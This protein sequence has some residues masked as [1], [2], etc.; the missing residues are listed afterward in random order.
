MTTEFYRCSDIMNFVL[1]FFI[2]LPGIITICVFVG[3]AFPPSWHGLLE[4][5]CTGLSCTGSST[6]CTSVF[7][8]KVCITRSWGG[9]ESRPCENVPCEDLTKCVYK[10]V[11]EWVDGVFFRPSFNDGILIMNH[12]G[13]LI[14]HI[15][16]LVATYVTLVC[17]VAY[18]IIKL[19]L[20]IDTTLFD[21]VMGVAQLVTLFIFTYIIRSPLLSVMTDIYT[22]FMR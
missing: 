3:S 8:E 5:N 14:L 15:Y 16:C 6:Q 2:M 22:F 12:I 21:D 11:S 17:L 18:G 4:N 9:P 10:I 19:Q 7:N 1:Y 20:Y 13:R